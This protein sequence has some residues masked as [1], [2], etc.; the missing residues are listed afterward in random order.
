MSCVLVLHEGDIRQRAIL[1]KIFSTK[2]AHLT[3]ETDKPTGDRSRTRSLVG[4]GATKYH[5]NNTGK[6]YEQNAQER[7]YWV[8]LALRTG[9]FCTLELRVY[10]NSAAAAVG[11]E[12][13]TV[14]YGG[15]LDF[16]EHQAPCAYPYPRAHSLSIGT[17]WSLRAAL[18]SPLADHADLSLNSSYT[19][20]TTHLRPSSVVCHDIPPMKSFPSTSLSLS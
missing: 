14:D 5:R 13:P 20:P 2:R 15:S 6:R 18:G 10:T 4:A 3:E 9:S 7:Y 11:K 12:K 19:P 1:A 17:P 16:A 8:S